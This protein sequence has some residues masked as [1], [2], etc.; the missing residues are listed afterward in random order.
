MNIDMSFLWIM[1]SS[2]GKQMVI[3]ENNLIAIDGQ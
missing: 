1:D 2:F 3:K